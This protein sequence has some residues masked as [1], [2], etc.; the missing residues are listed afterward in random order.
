MS[1]KQGSKL[2]MITRRGLLVGSIAITGG[3]AFGYWKYKQPHDNPLQKNLKA[4][5][6]ALS[7]YILIT[8]EGITLYSPRAE[9]G[10]GVYTT[11]SAMVA[12][13]LDVTLEQVTVKHSPASNIYYNA[14]VL[15]EGI[16][17]AHT[18][19]S[20]IA[21]AMR[22]FVDVPAKLYGLQITG[23]SSSVAD[24][25]TKMRTAGA[26]ARQTLIRAAAQQW[27][28]NAD[29]LSTDKGRVIAPNGDSLSYLE[30]ATTAAQI[31]P[32]TNPR[33]KPRS[34]WK[35]LGKSQKRV[36]VVAKSTG[37]A[38]FSIDTQLPNMLYATVKMNPKLGGKMHAYDATDA[39]NSLASTILSS[40]IMALRSSRVTP[41]THY[42]P[43]TQSNL[44]G[45]TPNIKK[46]KS[47]SP[48]KSLSHL[49]KSRKIVN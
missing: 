38:Q 30:L 45:V 16:P 2:G 43:R 15:H 34:E 3:V 35:I 20:N 29:D 22:S 49:M 13:E 10:Q 26:A 31:E 41:G 8:Q 28:I 6:A 42:V 44:I 37:T 25:F 47:K 11:L 19:V 4:G 23:G 17:F 7:A 27:D 48:R 18:D 1:E 36:D 39:K 9:M 12:E 21:E 32:P 33:L 14:A 5:Q 46:S 40:L 24:A